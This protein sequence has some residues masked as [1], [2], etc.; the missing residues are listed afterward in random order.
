MT[1][2]R[3]SSRWCYRL[4]FSLILVPYVYLLRLLSCLHTY[5]WIYVAAGRWAKERLWLWLCKRPAQHPG[6]VWQAEP[7]MRLHQRWL[8]DLAKLAR[9]QTAGLW[10]SLIY[11]N[12]PEVADG[13]LRPLQVHKWNVHSRS[14]QLASLW[15]TGISK[16][17]RPLWNLESGY[18]VFQHLCYST[19][20]YIKAGHESI[21]S[22][23]PPCS[24]GFSHNH[25][26]PKVYQTWQHLPSI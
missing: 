1:T 20:S 5:Y 16:C 12:S 21:A 25:Q 3:A 14:F 4:K 7:M 24:W 17:L 22:T 18:R 2:K 19:V 13:Q 23:Y 6:S 15:L 26:L 8:A 9:E 10:L 11:S